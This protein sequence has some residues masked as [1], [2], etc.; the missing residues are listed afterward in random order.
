MGISHVGLPLR[1]QMHL[2][3][4]QLGWDL[5]VLL[6]YLNGILLTIDWFVLHNL[7]CLGLEHHII[8][9]ALL[10]LDRHSLLDRLRVEVINSDGLVL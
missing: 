3:I 10:A 1:L 7:V 6:H 8:V 4:G 5:V 2:N 9:S